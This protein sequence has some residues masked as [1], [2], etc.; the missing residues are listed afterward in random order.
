MPVD[1]AQAVE[2]LNDTYVAGELEVLDPVK[3]NDYLDMVLNEIRNFKF[4]ILAAPPSESL[5]LCYFDSTIGTLGVWNGAAWV[6]LYG[7]D[8]KKSV[9]DTNNDGIVD[10]SDKLDNEHGS[11]YLSRANHTGSQAASTISDFNDAVRTNRLDQMTAPTADVSFNNRK[12]TMLADAVNEQDA[13]NLRTLHNLLA[14]I[15]GKT[16]VKV[17]ATSNVT[18]SGL[19]TINDYTLN[20]D[21]R[22]LLNGQ[23]NPEENGLYNAKSGA[24]V[25]ASDGDTWSKYISAYVFVEVGTQY[26][27]TGWLCTVDAG[28]VLDTSPITFVQFTGAAQI[29][30]GDGIVKDGNELSVDVDDATI[31]IS[32]NKLRIKAGYNNKKDTALITGDGTT[33]VFV[34]EH[35]CGATRALQ[36][37]I[38]DVAL[39][40]KQVF[41]SV[42]RTADD[43]ITVTFKYAPADEYEYLAVII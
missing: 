21:D 24:W 36:C 28:G 35:D 31:E 18:R 10:N 40:Y 12:I 2:L 19:L 22:V 9:Y 41:P 42:K 37:Q 3:L 17:I 25:R 14:G 33:T 13:V 43:E 4:H 6:Y 23:T 5:A 39:D 32:S 16:S 38:L 29:V 26:A 8:M 30:A 27:D 1:M 15:K 20:T 11:Y 7:G 34:V